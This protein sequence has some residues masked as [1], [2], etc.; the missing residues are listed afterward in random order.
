M[1]RR[2]LAITQSGLLISAALAS[3]CNKGSFPVTPT[4][5][6]TSAVVLQGTR[7]QGNIAL[8]SGGTTSF[9][10]TLIA[11]ALTQ[12]ASAPHYVQR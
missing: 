2:L 6:A 11:R 1:N 5:I 7:Y 10:M 3:G 12:G 4:P 8:A 9:N